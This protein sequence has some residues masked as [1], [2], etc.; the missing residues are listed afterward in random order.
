MCSVVWGI[1]GLVNVVPRAWIQDV[2]KPG[3]FGLGKDREKSLGSLESSW[4]KVEAV[5]IPKVRLVAW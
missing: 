2:G 5:E 3:D 1:D 4:G